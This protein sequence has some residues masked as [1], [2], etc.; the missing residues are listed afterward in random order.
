MLLL[1]SAATR[2]SLKG[3]RQHR[4]MSVLS[5]RPPLHL[6][7]WSGNGKVHVPATNVDEYLAALPRSGV[8]R[9]KSYAISI[10]WCGARC[11]RDD[12]VRDA[13]VPQRDG[14]LPR[15]VRRVQGALQPL[16]STAE[17]EA[18]SVT[19]ASLPCRQ[20][21]D[22]VPGRPADPAR[23][24]G[25]EDGSWG[26][27]RWKPGT[28]TAVEAASRPARSASA[29]NRS[30]LRNARTFAGRTSKTIAWVSPERNPPS[31]TSDSNS[32]DVLA[33]LAARTGRRRGSSSIRSAHP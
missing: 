25:A 27:P 18:R 15:L 3:D 14:P 26:W 31:C 24:R 29:R 1:A 23:A 4:P 30:S 19:T 12:H 21:D 6:Q 33:L 11:H 13:R 9:W 16:P 17:V 2:L 28:R 32:G 8:A 7:R 20:G 5:H 22:P 10:R